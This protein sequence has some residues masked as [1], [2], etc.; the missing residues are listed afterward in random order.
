MNGILYKMNPQF[1]SGMETNLLKRKK[2]KHIDKGRTCNLVRDEQR[3]EQRGEQRE[4][5]E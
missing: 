1:S 2:E 4:E 5:H 3:D